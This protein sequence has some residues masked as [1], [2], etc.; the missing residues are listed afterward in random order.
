MKYINKNYINLLDG[1]FKET[2]REI[3]WVI[4]NGKWWSDYDDKLEWHK[5]ND[6]FWIQRYKSF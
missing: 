1:G 2:T 5:Q 6:G 3:G 4:K